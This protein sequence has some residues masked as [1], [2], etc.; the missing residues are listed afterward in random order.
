[1]HQE[2]WQKLVE[3]L[4]FFVMSTGLGTMVVALRG[5]RRVR[6]NKLQRQKLGVAGGFIFAV[7]LVSWI[8]LSPR[9]APRPAPPS[10]ASSQ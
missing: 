2:L 6:M 10:A 4:L 8:A 9:L 3:F 7:G 5:P 1:M